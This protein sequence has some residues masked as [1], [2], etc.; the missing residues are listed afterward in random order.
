MPA[1]KAPD[2][3]LDAVALLDRDHTEL[4]RLFSEFEKARQPEFKLEL[5][6]HICKK[7][8]VHAQVEEQTFYPAIQAIPEFGDMV[9]ESLQEHR[10]LKALIAALTGMETANVTFG[11]RMKVLGEEFG[12]HVQDEDERML[13]RVRKSLSEA[14]LIELGHRMNRLM[15]D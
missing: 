6:Q 15:H 3:A 8:A 13:P 4:K 12:R 7:L 11:P 1:G 14:V 10:Q 5:A 9:L 2:T